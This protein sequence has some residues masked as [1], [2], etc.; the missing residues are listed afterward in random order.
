M[1]ELVIGHVDVTAAVTMLD[2]YPG[3]TEYPTMAIANYKG[4]GSN[5]LGVLITDRQY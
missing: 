2:W 4:A 1:K 3:V 5:A